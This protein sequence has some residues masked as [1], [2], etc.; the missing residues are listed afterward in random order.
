[1]E[2][3]RRIQQSERR[4]IDKAST[5]SAPLGV[6]DTFD[7]HV[8]LMFELLAAAWQTDATRI[9][10]FMMSR[11]LSQRTY[12]QIGVTEQHHSVSHHQNNADKMA[13]V[14]R[15]NTYYVG[16]YAKFLEKLKATEDGGGSLLD[17]SLIFYGAGMGDSNSHASDPLPIIAIGGGAGKGH[18][19]LQVETRTSVGCLWSAVANRFGAPMER[20][21]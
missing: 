20:F 4:G 11:E 2:I 18:R 9:F 10:T 15:I 17:H 14:A 16:M 13:K 6:P 8:N 7:E 3:E 12:P 1:R 19:H 5:T 21:G